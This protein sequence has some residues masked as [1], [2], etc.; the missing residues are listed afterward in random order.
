MKRQVKFLVTVISFLFAFS[1]STIYAEEN[2]DLKTGQDLASTLA[3]DGKGVKLHDYYELKY[4]D[5]S[6]Y[7][8]VTFI[9]S[10]ETGKSYFIEKIVRRCLSVGDS[11]RIKIYMISV[12][13]DPNIVVQ[14]EIDVLEVKILE[15]LLKKRPNRPMIPNKLS[16]RV[17]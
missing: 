10:K 16:P 4:S 7:A 14:F 12:I 6:I 11:G 13:S 9:A 15:G 1:A 17:V 2:V 3:K 5:G 8:M